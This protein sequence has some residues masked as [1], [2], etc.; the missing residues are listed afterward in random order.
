MPIFML[1]SSSRWSWMR[2]INGLKYNIKKVSQ[3]YI[4]YGEGPGNTSKIKDCKGFLSYY[5]H[6]ELFYMHNLSKFHTFP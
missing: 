3:K 6:V 1:S 4:N 5:H 2:S